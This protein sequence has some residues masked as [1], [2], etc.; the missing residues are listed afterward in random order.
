MAARFK[1]ACFVSYIHADEDLGRGFVMQFV[2]ALQ[3]E[4][5]QLVDLRTLP[6]YSD[7]L[8]K[9]GQ[10]WP[11]ALSAALCHS[12]CMVMVYSPVYARRTECLREYRAMERIEAQRRQLLSAGHA[13]AEGFIIPVVLR[14]FDRLPATLKAERQAVDFSRFSLADVELKRNPRFTEA[15]RAI[16]E[17]I[18]DVLD[19]LEPLQDKACD[20]CDDFQL[21][22]PDG[23]QPLTAPGAA[24]QPGF[25]GR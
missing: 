8:L 25:P 6:I 15:V 10:I 20:G 22:A 12:L 5:E 9:P 23:L 2:Q 4:L 7:N 14:G 21:P 1:Y 16:A 3:G 19:T 24:W 11:A 17:R 13:L 18:S